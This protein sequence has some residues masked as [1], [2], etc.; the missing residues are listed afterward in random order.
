MK[1]SGDFGGESMVAAVAL[2][3]VLPS[4]GSYRSVSCALAAGLT[5]SV[6]Q[7]PVSVFEL[8]LRDFY[9]FECLHVLGHRVVIVSYSFWSHPCSVA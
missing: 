1:S 2:V 8:S 7:I 3:V 6:E 5:S 9:L 4:G